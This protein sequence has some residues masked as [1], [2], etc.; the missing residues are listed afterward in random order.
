MPGIIYYIFLLLRF[1]IKNKDLF[2]TN[3]EIHK[4]DTRQRNNLHLRSVSLKKFQT[5]VFYMGIKIYNSL[6]LH[7]KEESSNINRFLSVL[8]NFLSENSFY[9]LGDFYDFCKSK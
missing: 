2:T 5:G 4:L 9:S 3:N 1:A 8:K 7:I 6:S